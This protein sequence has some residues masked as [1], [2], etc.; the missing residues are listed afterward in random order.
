MQHN[1]IGNCLYQETRA[2]FK[3]ILLSN[4]KCDEKNSNFRWLWTNF[5]QIL[6]WETL[7]CMTDDDYYGQPYN[8][9]ILKKCDSNNQKQGWECAGYKKRYIRQP[10]SNHSHRYLEYGQYHDYVTTRASWHGIAQWRRY[11]TQKD[12]CS[13]GNLKK[14]C[15]SNE[16]ETKISTHFDVTFLE[17]SP[18]Y[19]AVATL[20]D[21]IW[22]EALNNMYILRLSVPYIYISLASRQLYFSAIFF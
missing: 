22:L 14:Q 20:H 13:Q 11:D 17:R 4:R 10:M 3:F 8:Y 21:L 6:H 15:S 19:T 1:L 18:L 2:S 5:G 7:E 9:V 12:V 16:S